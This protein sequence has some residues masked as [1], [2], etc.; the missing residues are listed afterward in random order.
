MT[1][2]K[3]ES[4]HGSGNPNLQ[5]GELQKAWGGRMSKKD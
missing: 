4:E 3:K 1:V 5:P 2:P